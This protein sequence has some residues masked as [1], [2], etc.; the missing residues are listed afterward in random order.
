MVSAESVTI[1]DRTADP[2][3][4][5][6]Q[7]HRVVAWNRGAEGLLGYEARS[8]L[9]KRCY[10]ILCGTDL[11][12][13]RFCDRYCPVLNM[14]RLDERVN[15]FQVNLRTGTGEMIRTSISIIALGQGTSNSA[16]IHILKPMK[17]EQELQ[18][19]HDQ[20]L[21]AWPSSS[22]IRLTRRE[23]HVLRQLAE[24]AVTDQIAEHLRISVV[25][26]RNH[27]QAILRKLRVHSRIEAV[28]LAR[29][30]GII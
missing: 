30:I 11:F 27:I 26:V 7:K 9:G 23:I 4:A 6:D 1:V 16:I 8:M 5:V 2:A 10:R 13:N 18:S 29:S 14:A 19:N 24:G 21:S 3:F 28:S 15:P 25:T 17:Q 22:P 20:K 12:G